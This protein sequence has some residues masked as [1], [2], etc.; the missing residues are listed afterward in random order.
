MFTDIDALSERLRKDIEQYSYESLSINSISSSDVN[1]TTHAT[2]LNQQEA[3]FMYS[4]L[5][6]DILVDMKRKRN[7]IQE[8]ITFFR[9]QNAG[10]FTTIDEFEK[11]Y[12]PNK[13]IWWY[14]RDCFIYE[15]L[16][17]AVRTLDIGTLYKMQPFIKDLH[18]QIKSSCLSSTIT[19]VYRGQ[20][21]RSEEFYKHKNNI[22]GLLS[23]NNFLSTST[24]KEVGL[25]FAFANMNRPCY[26][27]I[28]F[29]IEINQSAHHISVANIENFSYFQTENEV[30][31]SMCSVFRIKS[32]IKM[33][34]GIW[35][36]QVTLT[37]DEDK[38]LKALTLCMKEIIEVPVSERNLHPGL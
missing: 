1:F 37:G 38:Q 35:N 33:D 2:N 5:I 11:N 21:M 27:A 26:E 31:F 18:H 9:Q 13:A 32:I 23:I 19:T 17:Q 6:R 15:V 36:F 7:S 12:S 29:E 10:Q 16:N 34:N 20:A 4:I 14:T 22:G 8:M 24:D 30:L 3:F 28:L 25:A